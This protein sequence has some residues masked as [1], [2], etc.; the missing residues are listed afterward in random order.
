MQTMTFRRQLGSLACAVAVSIAAGCARK[1]V[2]YVPAPT[3]QYAPAGSE[4]AVLSPAAMAPGMPDPAT[5][6]PPAVT[7]N[8]V[9]VAQAPPAPVT[10]VIPVQPG[11]EY[12]WVPGYWEWRGRW[13]WYGGAWVLRPRPGVIWVGPRW[14]RRP[15]G[16]VHIHGRWR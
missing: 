10:E 5:A 15:H 9:V 1:E 4:S 3:Y 6:T 8:S 14:E 16:Y 11:P 12:V 13:V 2:V 7:N